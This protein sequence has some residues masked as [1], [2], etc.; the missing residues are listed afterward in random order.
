[1]VHLNEFTRQKKESRRVKSWRDKQLTL[2]LVYCE[3]IIGWVYW[4]DMVAFIVLCIF[5]FIWWQH[6]RGVTV[7]TLLNSSEPWS[8]PVT[9]MKQLKAIITIKKHIIGTAPDIRNGAPWWFPSPTVLSITCSVYKVT[10]L[11]FS[12]ILQNLRCQLQEKCW[13][14][15]VL[16]FIS[17]LNLRLEIKQTR[18]RLMFESTTEIKL[19]Q[20][21][22][23]L[24]WLRQLHEH[25]HK[26]NHVCLLQ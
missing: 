24:K 4:P 3:T 6:K 17:N 5:C 15:Y 14:Q 7:K 11:H 8:A 18:N 1:M 23:S 9:D 10:Q 12:C 16:L 13:L 19:F 26:N 25:V 22:P 20:S 2:S 21:S